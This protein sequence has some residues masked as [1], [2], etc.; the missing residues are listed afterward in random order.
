VSFEAQRV[1]HERAPCL[2]ICF[3]VFGPRASIC[4][5][6]AGSVRD[7]DAGQRPADR[8]AGSRRSVTARWLPALPRTKSTIR[9]C[10]LARAA[11]RARQSADCGQ[12]TPKKIIAA[13]LRSALIAPFWSAA[14][15]VA[16]LT[17]RAAARA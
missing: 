12:R 2:G 5:E 4:G 6:G 10:S 17:A 11:A 9:L 1:A 13:T 8:P 3:S 15:A 7:R 16:A 14:T